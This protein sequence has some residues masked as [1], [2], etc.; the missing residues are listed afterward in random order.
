MITDMACQRWRGSQI[1]TVSIIELLHACA[2]Y[3]ANDVRLTGLLNGGRE[4][5]V[6]CEERSDLDL[7]QLGICR[8]SN[9]GLFAYEL[10]TAQHR[11]GADEQVD[12]VPQSTCISVLEL[13]DVT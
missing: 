8:F 3:A 7:T 4:R 2:V 12:K 5:R 13:D 9:E 10:D 11:G 1:D 6:Q